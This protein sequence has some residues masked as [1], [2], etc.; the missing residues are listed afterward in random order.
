MRIQILSLLLLGPVCSPAGEDWR[1]LFEKSNGV[2]TCRLAETI[3]YCRRLDS[4]CAWVRYESFGVSPRGRELP[5][6]IVS[7]EEAFT[8]GA[9][10]KTGKEIILIQSGIHAG[11]IDGKDASLMLMREIALTRTLAP[12]LDHAILLFVPVFNVD[13]YERFG[14]FNRINQNGPEETGW[15]T[16]A[17]NL[18]LNRD[19]LKAD[20][21]EM[22]SMLRLFQ[23][24]LPDLTVDCHVTDG[25]D[26]QYDV[27][28]SVET[29]PNMEPPVASWIREVLLPRT[30]AETGAAGHGIFP[31]V[32]LREDNRPE[33][34]IIAG[35]TPPRFSTGYLAVQNRAGLLVETHMLKPYR[36]RVRATYTLLQAVLRRVN[37]APGALRRAVLEADARTVRAGSSAGNFLGLRF[38]I[39]P[40]STPRTF[41]GIE[42]VEESSSVSGGM[43]RV[44]TGKPV[45]IT[46]PFLDHVIVTDSVTVPFAYLIPPEWNDLAGVLGLHGVRMDRL[47]E[48]RE[49]EVESY[50]FTNV[51]FRERPYEG[52][53]TASY[54]AEPVQER[55]VFPEGT[56]L[57]RTAQRSAKAAMHLLE[58][59]SAD[60]FAAWGFLNTV[61][62]QKE[63]AEDYVME[64]EGERMLE[65][66]P[67]LRR[68]YEEAL[69]ADS[70]FA[71]R[72][73]ARLNW[74]YLRSR[75]ADP[76]LNAYPAARLPLPADIPTEPLP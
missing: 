59:R 29:G 75:W 15:R 70:A 44:S 21:P 52:R 6:V 10:A 57:I 49:L 64:A 14:P 68:R 74:L 33:R 2:R 28:Y 24:W 4:A 61:F 31:Y 76:L 37:E 5:L 47:T 53:Q 36:T 7:R 54:T 65:A 13:G 72:P 26:M 55:R 8:P 45:T 51:Q 30:L 25:V 60:S 16:T 20:A 27:T 69:A 11:E 63:Y 35:A 34:G 50:R 66:D 58:P 3:R 32:F 42:S 23:A 17:Q 12:L 46:V 62:E 40:G 9:A 18:N 48:E 73:G 1:I 43:K 19:Y 39:G 41:L 67:A 22:R 56:I 71:A 38:G